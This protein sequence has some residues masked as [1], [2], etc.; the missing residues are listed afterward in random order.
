MTLSS[1]TLAACGG[2]GS[3]SSPVVPSTPSE[4]TAIAGTGQVT[5][6]WAYSTGATSYNISRGTTYYY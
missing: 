4:L 3:S 1:V 5:L 6:V 2:G